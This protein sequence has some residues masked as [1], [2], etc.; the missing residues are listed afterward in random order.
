MSTWRKHLIICLFLGL[1]VFP[2]TFSI[3]R[4]LK[5]RRRLDHQRTLMETGC[6]GDEKLIAFRKRK[7]AIYR[8]LI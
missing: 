5:G 8:E 1:L 6:T 4:S 3:R 7:A 2:S